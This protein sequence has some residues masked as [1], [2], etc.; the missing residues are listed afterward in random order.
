MN[1]L[2]K[3][4]PGLCLL[5]LM[6]V[7][8]FF[9]RPASGAEP[10]APLRLDLWNGRAPLG[11]GQFESTEVWITVYRPAQ[12]NGTAVVICPGGG[13]GGHAIQPEG[14]GIAAWLNQHGIVG[15]VLE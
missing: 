3:S 1:R 4:L 10:V 14:H 7:G 5:G 13:Y 6:G 12:P 8:L 15:V 11:D 2:V 9:P